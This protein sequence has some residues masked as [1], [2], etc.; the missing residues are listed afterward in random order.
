MLQAIP[1]FPRRSLITAVVV[2]ALIAE[3]SGR[4][5]TRR[6]MTLVGL[7]EHVEQMRAVL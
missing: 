2:A 6:P 3:P 7:A 4:A 1:S 5:Q